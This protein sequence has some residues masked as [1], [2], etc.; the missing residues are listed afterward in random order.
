MK[1]TPK[2]SLI[3]AAVIAVVLLGVTLI[4]AT[5]VDQRFLAEVKTSSAA[6]V[7]ARTDALG[8]LFGS[9]KTQL[10]FN[11]AKKQLREGDEATI[12]SATNEIG[13]MTPSYVNVSFFAWPDGRFYT[14]KGASGSIADRAYF[15]AAMGG[16]DFVVGEA[17]LS[18]DTGLPVS[19]I[20]KLVK[21]P[22]GAIKG[23]TAY[24]VD[25]G[26]LSEIVKGLKLGETGYGWI[27]DNAGLTIAHP[28]PAFTMKFNVYESD[29][30]GFVG[31]AAFGKRIVDEDSGLG[32]YVK[33]D[34]TKVL[35]IFATIPNT[36]NWTLVLSVPEVEL[37]RASLQ[38][39]NI[40]VIAF[41][42]A[43]VFGA[44][45]AVIVARSIVRPVALVKQ[46]VGLIE[47]GDLSLEGLDIAA[48][49]KLVVRA[50][51]V[52]DLG[53][54]LDSL[55]DSL[56]SVVGDIRSASKQVSD[57]SQQLSETA[58][59]ISQG[60]NEQAASIE[61]LSASVEELASTIRQNAD[62]TAQADA[63]AR[64]VAQNADESG[65]AVSQTVASMKEIAARISIIEEIAR[66]T[67]LLAL[68][69]AIEAARAGDAGKGFAVVASEVRKLAERSQKA[70]GEINEL[71]K[72]SVSVAGEAGKRLDELVP[73]IKKAADLIQEIAA[74]SGE[75]A[76]GADQIAKG[77]T[78]M[79]TVVQQNASASEELAS[80][81][82]ELAAQ[83]ERLAQTIGF[84]KLAKAADSAA[85]RSGPAAAAE[86][87]AAQAGRK[88]PAAP[89][90]RLA[91][92]SAAKKSE[93]APA[94]SRAI[95]LPKQGTPGAA[96]D[97]DF[98]EF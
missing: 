30:Q 40:M 16:Q 82:E 80:T 75:Q 9:I 89:T 61:E 2:V 93:A 90:A 13:T 51:E 87:S 69:A 43:L 52:G 36:P 57:G 5:V 14:S 23:L 68:N 19:N 25:L 66:Q 86:G 1:L 84:F 54:S 78:Q 58:Q 17:V 28:D 64:R 65:R 70:A 20:V 62:N 95:A 76:G 21:E 91:V 71:S 29:K 32:N 34:G 55:V 60:A 38:V 72:T 50:D 35:A 47:Q 53:R 7:S 73:D 18:K 48:T 41:I 88:A 37:R 94:A 11:A 4:V 96:D 81:A 15:K 42:V 27:V 24:Q 56:T 22:S 3:I 98:E 12:K 79:D 77:V 33:P 31:L 85:A 6:T 74:A 39:I 10:I 59:G 92:S 49:R 45:V 97:A 44:T 83:A 63:L 8:E 46:G 67:N 26:K